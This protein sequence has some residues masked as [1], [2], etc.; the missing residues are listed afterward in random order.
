MKFSTTKYSACKKEEISEKDYI[1]N[2][3]YCFKKNQNS[4]THIFQIIKGQLFTNPLISSILNLRVNVSVLQA[5]T[6]TVKLRYTNICKKFFKSLKNFSSLI[7]KVISFDI[8]VQKREKLGSFL[9]LCAFR[10]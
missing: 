4:M 5:H 6:A 7:L 2:I 1:S 10:S 3:R 9:F 8:A